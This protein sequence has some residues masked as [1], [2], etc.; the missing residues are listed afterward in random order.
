MTNNLITKIK[1]LPHL[2]LLIIL[3]TIWQYVSIA[4]MAI[5][6]WPNSL[7]WLNVGLLLAFIVLSPVYESLLLLILSIPF[8]VAIPNSRFDDLSMWR[9]L[10]LVLF[11]VWLI[12]DKKLRIF[13]RGGSASGGNNIKFLPWDKY[14]AAFSVV[15]IVLAFV[16]GNFRWE[17]IKEVLFWVNIY[18]LYLVMINTLRGKQ[19]IFE[20]IRYVVWSLAIIITLGF[21]QLFST[22]LVH[23]DVFWVYWASNITRLYYGTNFANVALYSN[24]WFS[25]GNG[26]PE[27]RMFSI[28]PDSQSFAYI[29]IFG[30]C[31]GTALTRNVFKHIKKWLWSGIRFAGLAM[32][33][34]GTR[35]VWV[36]MVAPFGVIAVS[37]FT[38]FQKH[39]SKKFLW[40]FAIIFCPVQKAFTTLTRL[41]TK[42]ESPCGKI[43]LV[44]LFI[45]PGVLALAILFS[46]SILIP[47]RRATAN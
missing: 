25:Y 20:I 26:V 9:I 18:F 10:Y 47:A 3:F 21:T 42:A 37:Y 44:F 1:E 15:G 40:P 33:L 17:A 46:R 45:I 13:A 12:K 19:Q 41:P 29:C 5:L 14:L 16:F 7:V 38:G 34:S 8:Y 36:G 22:F 28:M 23:L 31:I 6:G 2:K 35:A 4:G 24:S 32:I 43:A 11:V 39:L 30:L 27:L